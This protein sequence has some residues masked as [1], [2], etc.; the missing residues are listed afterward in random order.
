MTTKSEFERELK[1]LNGLDFYGLNRYWVA[2]PK[3]NVITG[4]EL[5]LLKKYG[6]KLISIRIMHNKLRV[7]IYKIKSD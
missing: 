5:Q 6:Y 2:Y 3:E 7:L 1:R 4:K